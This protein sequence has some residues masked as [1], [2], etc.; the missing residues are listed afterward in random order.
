MA[1]RRGGLAPSSVCS[2]LTTQVPRPG[3]PSWVFPS[4][5][6][7]RTLSPSTRSAV[8]A[9]TRSRRP[10]RATRVH[11]WGWHQSP[12][13]CGSGSCASTPLTRSGRTVTAS[14]SPRVMPR[15]CC[16]HCCTSRRSRRSTLTTRC[17][18]RPAVTLDDLKT[19]RQLGS[20]CPGHPEYRWTSGVEA[21]TGPLG[22]GVAN[23]VGMAI[24]GELAGRTDTTVRTSTLFDFDVYALAGDG[25]MMEGISSEAASLAGAPA[26]CPTCAGSTTRTG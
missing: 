13:R 3:G 23:S 22:Q 1:A 11:P 9:W 21:T 5:C 17:C 6:R 15:P 4:P 14:C 8:C 7:I 24:A 25:C 19:F 26:A 2:D 16:G 12:T 10:T 18:G 20:H